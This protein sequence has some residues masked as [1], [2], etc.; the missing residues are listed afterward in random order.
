M[1]VTCLL[2][3]ASATILAACGSTKPAPSDKLADS[4]ASPAA[5]APPA[6]AEPTT[7]PAVEPKATSAPTPAKRTE[8]SSPSTRSA[9]ASAPTVAPAPAPVVAKPAVEP[10][11]RPTPVAPP[12]AAPSADPLV[13]KPI[14]EANC[15]KCH[16]V[17]GVPAKVIKE[18]FPKIL[19][20]DAAY[21]SKTTDEAVVAIL[22][23]GKGDDMKP[24]KDKLSK[25][26]MAA[27]AA[28]IRTLGQR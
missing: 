8:P 23:Q 7:T 9:P 12:A 26:E 18:K 2:A 13:G 27:V 24:F 4:A 19:P 17:I 6:A 20:F 16:G 3:L 14:Y 28:Y 25:P 1:K 15:R 11:P 10:A 22:M 21:F 5:I